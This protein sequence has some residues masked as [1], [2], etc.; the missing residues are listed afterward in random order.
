MN[1]EKHEVQVSFVR[2][3]SQAEHTCPVC[4]TTF[5]G[6]RLRVYCTNKC[7]KK[8]AWLRSGPTLNEKRRKEPATI[9][10]GTEQ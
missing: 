7:R 5:V 9:A 3:Y 6:P 4:G 10:E 2:H 1:N 8:A